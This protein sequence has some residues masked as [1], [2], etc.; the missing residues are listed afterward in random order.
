MTSPVDGLWTGVPASFGWVHSPLMKKGQ[1]FIMIFVEI[2]IDLACLLSLT[3][4]FNEGFQRRN[5]SE[6]NRFNGFLISPNQPINFDKSL[7]FLVEGFY[8]V[9]LRLPGNVCADAV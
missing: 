7:I 9:M 3:P 5:G 4:R 2:V 1:L 8:A 6:G